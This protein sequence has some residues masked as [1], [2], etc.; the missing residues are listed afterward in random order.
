MIGEFHRRRTR[1]WRSLAAVLR[2]A[3]SL[4]NENGSVSAFWPLAQLPSDRLRA[5]LAPRPIWTVVLAVTGV[6][7]LTTSASAEERWTRAL[8]IPEVP[9]DD[10]YTTAIIADVDNP[11][12]CAVPSFLRIA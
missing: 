11:A 1:C 12:S 6:I 7:L 4:G 5:P 3:R 2:R 10:T 9:V 8:K